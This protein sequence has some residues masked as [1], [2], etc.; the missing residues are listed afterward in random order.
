M[1]QQSTGRQIAPFDHIFN[2]PIGETANI[3]FI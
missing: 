1:K 3:N 2:V